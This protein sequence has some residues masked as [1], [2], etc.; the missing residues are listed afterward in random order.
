MRKEKTRKE[1]KLNNSVVPVSISGTKIILDQLMNCI[2]KIKINDNFGT[3]SFCTIPFENNETKNFLVTNYHVFDNNYYKTNTKI[4][5]LLNDEKEVKI[6]DLTIPRIIYFNQENDITLIEL[7]KNDDI[8]FFLELDDNLFRDNSEIIY[9]SKSIYTLQ[10][11]QGRNAVVSYGLLV[12][13]NNFEIKHICS[14]EKGASGAPILNLET[15]KVIGV[16]RECSIFN[17]SNF[18]TFLKNPLIDFIQKNKTKI[19]VNKFINILNNHIDK[20]KKNIKMNEKISPFINNAYMIN[21]RNKIKR[22]NSNLKSPNSLTKY[23]KRKEFY[24]SDRKSNYNSKYFKNIEKEKNQGN[25]SYIQEKRNTYNNSLG[26]FNENK[27]MRNKIE[28]YNRPVILIQSC[29]RGFLC[30]KRV[31]RYI[32][33]IINYQSLFNRLSY[34]LH[35]CIRNYVLKVLKNEYGINK[36]KINTGIIKVNHHIKRYE[37]S[38]KIHSNKSFYKIIKVNDFNIKSNYKSTGNIYKKKQLKK[39]NTR[40]NT[41]IRSSGKNNYKNLKLDNIKTLR[42]VDSYQNYSTSYFNTFKNKNPE[43]YQ[44]ASWKNNIF[45]HQINEKMD[46]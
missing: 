35:I 42:K 6:I 43:K 20:K 16:H 19:K 38:N 39:D 40:K 10:Y 28:I 18:G 30:R 5:L 37:N 25:Q 11:P 23:N 4:N 22:K 33:L 21:N 27:S 26:F 45:F 15:N 3:G 34:V 17:E 29:F 9:E 2:C 13:I 14:T 1:K 44:N 31:I 8:K 46:L 36:N 41:P 12:S 7:N 32:T 24:L